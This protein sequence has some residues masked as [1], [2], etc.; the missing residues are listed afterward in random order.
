MDPLPPLN[1]LRAFE[2]VSRHMSFTRAADELGMTQSAVSYQIKLLEDRVGKPLFLRKPRQIALSDA[3]GRLAP[4][5]RE[6]F[7]TMREAV[8]G[9]SD[10]TSRT[11]VINTLETFAAR[12]L[13]TRL[14]S[15]QLAHP[16]IA[17]RLVTTQ[18][19]VD[20]DREEVDVA[21][22][23][24]TG[25]WPGLVR[26]K[27]MD[28]RFTPMLSPALAETIGGVREPADILKLP[29]LA[30]RDHW[31]PLWLHAAGLDPDALKGRP[32][33]R[34]SAQA[35]EAGMAIAGIGVGILTP[36]FYPSELALGQLIQPFDIICTDETA[37]HWLVYAQ[38][39][40]N[41]PQIRAFRN[42]ILSQAGVEGG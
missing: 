32:D 21:I 36:D 37:T 23:V 29:I 38:S 30:P 6:A 41:A 8:A 5:I 31:W 40:R 20:F 35:L 12:W 22:R 33:H 27:L 25:P 39:R 9:L 7:A 17:V 24:G 4:K 2:A 15:F 18:N 16:E 34:M 1:A 3:G 19:Y 10:D 26:H 14:G 42:W 28:I 11:L 13:V